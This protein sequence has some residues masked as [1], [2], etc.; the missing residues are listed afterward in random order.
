[1][2]TE[3]MLLPAL[4]HLIH[5]FNLSYNTSSWILSA[6]LVA[7]AVMTPVSGKLSDVY[8]KKKIMI[9]LISIYTFGLI[10]SPFSS[11][12]IMLLISRI[13]QGIGISV[14]PVTFGLV[15][16]QFPK[17][18]LALS[19]GIISSMFA[20]GS[21][22]G[23]AIGGTIVQYYGWRLTFFSIIPIAIILIYII[24]RF[25]PKEKYAH[26][27]INT[28]IEKSEHK[29]DVRGAILLGVTITTF[30]LF[31][32]SLR[33]D[34]FN[35]GGNQLTLF[36]I[37]NSAVIFFMIFVASF[38]S[39]FLFERKTKVPLIT[40]Q[41]FLDRRILSSNIILLI[42]GMSMFTIFQTLPILAQSPVPVGFDNS[43]IQM[44]LVQLPFAI[45]LLVLG[46]LV[47]VIITKIGQTTPLVIGTIAMSLGFFLLFFIIPNEFYISS[48]LVII[49][50]GISLTNVSSTNIVM[51]Q[52][53]FKQIGISLGISNLLRII[54]S[55]I[56]PTIAGLFMQTHLFPINSHDNQFHYFPSSS[57]YDLI[58][59]TM[60]GLSLSALCISLFLVKNRLKNKN[61][62][63]ADSN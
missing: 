12:F 8:G 14:F 4:P 45:V 56:G 7:G 33:N 61:Y 40:P 50:I 11:N 21:V 60:L 54:G 46:P 16:E 29:F 18:K 62:F 24:L 19:Q 27:N 49:S 23:L 44:S 30:L 39:F 36:G 63:T 20:G 53:S 47:G 22:L 13:L 38:A 58:F 1:M 59:G 31:I 15:R 9:I 51:M 35:E 48:Y 57:A 34:S 37:P 6:Y 43:A 41:L 5:E 32:T 17:N 42:V 26:E 10:I 28:K 25:I 2:Y 52:S 3:T 55:S